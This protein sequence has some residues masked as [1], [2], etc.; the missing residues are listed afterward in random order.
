MTFNVPSLRTDFTDLTDEASV[1]PDAHNQSAQA[2]MDLGN[3]VN[4]LP[5]LRVVTFDFDHTLTPLVS[6]TLVTLAPGEAIVAMTLSI[7]ATRASG[8]TTGD[9]GF[10]LTGSAAQLNF[11]GTTFYISLTNSWDLSQTAQMAP[12]KQFAQ[13]FGEFYWG[14]SSTS[15]S[16]F[17]FTLDDGAGGD[18]GLTAGVGRLVCL[19]QAGLMLP[20][21]PTVF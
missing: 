5:P 12:L 9:P 20:S 6:H 4:T 8:G 2:L 13:S 11:A 19:L 16:D 15:P 1:H 10:A 14:N 21:D 3:Y 7:P 18:P 17:A